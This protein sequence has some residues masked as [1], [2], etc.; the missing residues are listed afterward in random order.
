MHI[1]FLNIWIS[2]PTNDFSGDA[3]VVS[4]VDLFISGGCHDVNTGT[5]H[6]F[7]IFLILIK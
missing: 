3:A 5:A 6:L 4:V 7:K 1:Y 2:L